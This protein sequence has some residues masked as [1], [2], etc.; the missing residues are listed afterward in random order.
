M[1][2]PFPLHADMANEQGQDSSS[3][4]RPDVGASSASWHH[5]QND[6]TTSTAL[7]TSTVKRS[8]P[9]QT[10]GNGSYARISVSSLPPQRSRADV[11][12]EA[13]VEPSP[14]SV[15]SRLRNFSCDDDTSE[16]A[17]AKQCRRLNHRSSSHPIVFGRAT[18]PHD[19]NK[20]TA[21]ATEDEDAGEPSADVAADQSSLSSTESFTLRDR[22]DAINL[23]HPFGIRIWKPALYKKIR[24]VERNAEEDIHS[25]PNRFVPWYVRLG[26]VLWSCT[27]GIVL[28]T[29][30]LLSAIPLFILAPFSKQAGLYGAVLFGLGRYLFV[31]FGKYI[32]LVHNDMYRNEDVGFGRSVA[33]YLQWYTGEEQPSRLFFAPRRRLSEHFVEQLDPRERKL[34]MF[35][36]GRWTL[37]RVVFYV[38]FYVFVVPVMLV[39]AS[40]CWLGIFSV[41]MARVIS[42]IL[43]HLM[44]HPLALRF[45]P[46]SSFTDEE[47][48]NQETFSIILCTYRAFGLKYYKFTI[49]GI[50]IIV[51]NMMAAVFFTIGAAYTNTCPVS[52]IFSLSLLSIVP[53]AYFIGQAVASISAQSSM[54]LGATIN[55]FFSTIIEVYL[56]MVALQ[57]GKG[58]LVEGSITGSVM[59]GVLVLPGLSMCAGA[60]KRKTQRFNPKSTA[61]TSTMLLF[62][63][64]GA[65]GPTI[66]YDTFGPKEFKCTSSHLCLSWPKPIYKDDYTYRKVIYPMSIFCAVALFISYIIGLM[67]TLRTHAASIWSA[68]TTEEDEHGGHIGPNWSRRN[69]TIVLLGATL[70]YAII[71]EILVKSVDPILETF[72]ISPRMLGM[73]IF[74]LVPTT[75]ELLNAISFAMNGNVAL[76]M[77]IGSAYALQVCLL[78]IPAIVFGSIPYVATT[79]GPLRDHVFAMVFERWDIWTWI[80]CGF[81]YIHV[82][83]EGKSNYFKGSILLLGYFVL[84][85]GFYYNDLLASAG[86]KLISEELVAQK[87]L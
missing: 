6:L 3:S 67:F 24:S 52:M 31:P 18:L 84:L 69:S 40:L 71:A 11:S 1:P 62:S 76:S 47:G 80:S 70:L 81:L 20:D 8:Q 12:T 46:T 14:L 26:N 16:I 50:N 68:Q 17:A 87:I 51:F 65:L 36:R 56:Y 49:S 2:S 44:R 34:R 72:K 61:V 39:V 64:I 7:Q 15:R 41:P 13:R 83:A 28:F 4:R 58:V 75:T 32:Q 23:I 42:H 63:V 78:Q 33:D 55:A 29:V 85:A 86:M 37:A 82:H 43:V 27:F 21:I 73:T 54:T 77:E 59:A 79:E 53:L 5:E 60:F 66:F 10:F 9:G 57:K 22:Q 25:S 48:R 45:R 74:A 19:R 30:C 35:G 38:L